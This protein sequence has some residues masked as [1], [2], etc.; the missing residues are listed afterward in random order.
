MLRTAFDASER[1]STGRGLRCHSGS[2]SRAQWECYTPA[3]LQQWLDAMPTVRT[4]RALSSLAAA[5]RAPAVP[6]QTREESSP[7]CANNTETNVESYTCQ[8]PGI[9]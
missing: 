1:A 5:R 6:L 2:A 3:P 9:R 8:C 7:S 4:T